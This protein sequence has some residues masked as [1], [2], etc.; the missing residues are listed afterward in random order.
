M[1]TATINY[2][3]QLRSL[4]V[5]ILC[6]AFACGNMFIQRASN[7]DILVAE[8]LDCSLHGSTEIYNNTCFCAG[9]GTYYTDKDNVTSCF[10]G[11]GADQLSKDNVYKLKVPPCLLTLNCC[12]LRRAV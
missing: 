10:Q 5:F 8:G 9:S 2:Q 4:V 1:A 3:L 6:F 12:I 11:R 7:G